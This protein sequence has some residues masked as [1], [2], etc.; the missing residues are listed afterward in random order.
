MTANLSPQP[1]RSEGLQLSSRTRRLAHRAAALISECH[2]AQR[3]WTQVMMSPEYY[4]AEP[5]RGPDT[6][7]EFLYRAAG[8]MWHEPSAHERA[9]CGRGVS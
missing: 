2:Y 6:Y 9:S 5:G 7:A 8:S 4:T 3:R 1:G